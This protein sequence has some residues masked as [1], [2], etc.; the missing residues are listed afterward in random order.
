ME[1]FFIKSKEYDISNYADFFE[2]MI[3][4]KRTYKFEN[5]YIRETR[6]GLKE[7]LLTERY[8]K[9]LSNL[10]M[11][12]LIK[13]NIVCSESEKITIQYY[14]E[15]ERIDYAPTQFIICGN[16]CACGWLYFKKETK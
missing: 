4:L 9:D 5:Y 13:E 3:L 14:T 16:G 1:M 2:I 15:D 12:N 8:S 10:S 7:A 6:G 11:Y